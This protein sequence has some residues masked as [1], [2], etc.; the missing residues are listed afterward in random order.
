MCV[1]V[2]RL[3]AQDPDFVGQVA[4]ALNTTG[5]SGKYLELELTES[6]LAENMD[7]VSE[8]LKN[9]N[10]LGIRFS[11]DDFGTGYSSLSQLSKLPFDRLKIDK[12]SWEQLATGQEALVRAVILIAESLGMEV[13]AEGVETEDEAQALRALGCHTMQGFHFFKTLGADDF[14]TF[15]KARLMLEVSLKE[16]CPKN[17]PL[18]FLGSQG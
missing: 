15:C 17:D 7:R 10:A 8:N 16:L 6:V 13:V 2:S 12:V 11:I 4:D 1:N 3:Q 5:L 14:V 18:R 9:L